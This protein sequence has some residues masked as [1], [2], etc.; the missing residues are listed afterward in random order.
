MDSRG[1]KITWYLDAD[2]SAFERTMRKVRSESRATGEA[3]DR[4]LAR[5][6]SRASLSLK[7][8]RK[9]LSLSAQLFRDF[10]IA[11]RGFQLNA[12]IIGATAAGGA[13]IELSGA[14]IAA[15]GAA[16]ALPGILA[17]VA[18]A[19]GAVR[20]ATSGLEDAFKALGKGDID[21]LNEALKNLSPAA[22][23]FV[24]ASGE[25]QKAFKPIQ[26]AVQEQFFTGLGDQLREVAKV[27]LPTLR[28]GLLGV[29]AAMNTMAKEVARVSREP[30]F[31]GMIANTL[32]TT[33][34]S[35][36][37]LTKAV[38]PLARALAGLVSI[39]LPY[40]NMLSDWL[41]RQANVASEYINSARGQE[42]LTGAI[43]LGISALQKLGGL[44]TSV[45]KL[46]V[47]LFKVSN[48]EG[49]SF[50]DTL[51]QIVDNVNAW[52]QTAEGQRQLTALFQAA[53]TIIKELAETAGTFAKV[54]LTIVEGYNNLDGPLKEVVTQM[55]IWSA[56]MGP[57]LSYISSQYASLKLVVLAGREVF[58]AFDKGIPAAIGGF[59]R[60]RQAIWDIESGF[61]DARAASS[62]FTGTAG[63]I[64][65]TARTAFDGMDEAIR[66]F[67]A[68][69]LGAK[70]AT[71]GFTGVLAKLGTAIRFAFVT[72]PIGWVLLAVTALVGAFVWLY[73]N[74]EGFRNFWDATWAGI[75]D[76]ARGV[77]EWISGPFL[78]FF[79]DTWTNIQNGFQA[80]G[81][82][83]T[84]VGTN[85]MN[86][87]RA[88]GDFI[89]AVFNGIM[90][91]LQPFI[92]IFQL[93]IA[94]IQGFSAIVNT[95]F[96]AIGQIIFTVVST[97]VQIIGV[98]L[99]GSFM[100][101]VNNALIPL[102][103]WFSEVWNGIVKTVQDAVAWVGQVIMNG[104]NWLVGWVTGI[105][106]GIW[107]AIMVVWN[108]IA[109]FIMPIINGIA[110]FIQEKINF[111][112]T[113]VR[114]GFALIKQYIID[115]IVSAV[116]TV[117]DWIGKVATFVSNG[118][119]DAWNTLTQWT[120]RFRD[121][122]MDIINGLVRGVQQGAGKV[123]ET[124]QN[125]AKNAL[126]SVKKFF[127]IKSPSRVMAQMGDYIMEGLRNGI[128]RTGR[129]VVR[130]AGSV[131]ADVATG[132]SSQLTSPAFTASLNADVADVAG[133]SMA[134][135]PAANQ[136]SGSSST[137]NGVVI[138]QT[139]VIN[140]EL[141]MNQVNRDLT[142][143]LN[144]L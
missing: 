8:F 5:G 119:R 46:L 78:N 79:T 108:A 140:T 45:T 7:D 131:A 107:G 116:N 57:L 88:I 39:G 76:I 37:I 65:G 81:Q 60:L 47:T 121:S 34:E 66:V 93:V 118:I 12:L 50:I 110:A 51:T 14:L 13:I 126:D 68:N 59:K 61:K 97:I 117:R 1:G 124:V 95:V 141:D 127:G 72:T 86:V 115:P 48:Q 16:I 77:G 55:L 29:S 105:M 71:T 6:T 35:T 15:G 32:Q 33:A 18:G 44:L 103:Q 87:F 130:T 114:A 90:V 63:T 11:L 73:N 22:R 96:G 101:I 54:L 19:F 139:N 106:Q 64:G 128:V 3:V 136:S 9:D 135:R 142:W 31:Q 85:I 100:W 69:V 41:V 67:V 132:F 144:K 36:N 24:K 21:K 43:N 113:I 17:P 62:T 122:G 98:I 30:F 74:V 83:F 104:W 91:V 82:F 52:A 53:N 92:N 137:G 4:D 94:A 84:D 42:A 25:I 2:D 120:A 27:S 49:L 80:V 20:V 102:G 138:N 99:Y 58:Q 40:T 89:G 125:I 112:M 38:D 111:M 28:T 143:E 75:L 134:L 109:P 123:V 56:L 23:D 133:T 70:L 26:Q 10:Q 129:Q